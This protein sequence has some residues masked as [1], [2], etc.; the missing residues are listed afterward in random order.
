[1]N[2]SQEFNDGVMDAFAAVLDTTGFMTDEIYA[3]M[4]TLGC[5][6]RMADILSRTDNVHVADE[7]Y[8]DEAAEADG[9]AKTDAGKEND[10]STHLDD[11]KL[12]GVLGVL[13]TLGIYESD[14]EALYF[15]IDERREDYKEELNECYKA[16]TA[17]WNLTADI[18]EAVKCARLVLEEILE[19]N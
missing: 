13:K 15:R 11:Y 19:E 16:L 2:R 3:A 8:E 17:Q 6:D 9:A 1:M 12:Y 5:A 18:I 4:K 10:I 7:Y 14:P